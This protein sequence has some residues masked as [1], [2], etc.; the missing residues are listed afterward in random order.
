MVVA[1]ILCDK[2]GKEF[3]RRTKAEIP[4][5]ILPNGGCNPLRLVVKNF[6]STKIVIEKIAKTVETADLCDN[7]EIQL[8]QSLI[9]E[10]QD[11]KVKHEKP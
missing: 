5:S 8:Y 3:K 4:F 7:C 11:Y 1:Q 10:I 9:K 6:I 2:C